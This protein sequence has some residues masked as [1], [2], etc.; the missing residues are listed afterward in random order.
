LLRQTCGAIGFA[1]LH[2]RSVAE[3]NE[4]VR[5]LKGDD[6]AETVA[7]GGLEILHTVIDSTALGPL[8]DIVIEK[9][10]ADLLSMAAAIG[11]KVLHWTD[12]FYV[13]DYLILRINFPFEVARQ[14]SPA[15]ENPGIGRVSPGVRE[16]ARSRRTVDPVYDPKSYH[17]DLPPAAWAHGPHQDSWA[18]HSEDG[19]NIWW[20]MCDTPAEAGMVLYPE[21]AGKE[22]PREP[23]T[24]YLRAGYALPKPTLLP[25]AAG[26][27]LIFDP[28]IL[29]GTHLNVSSRTRVAI[30]LR[31]NAK[32]PRFSPDCFYAREFWRRA[33]DI[34]QGRFDA[35]LHL[36]REENLGAPPLP[37][38]VEWPEPLRTIQVDYA[39]D[40]PICLG[41]SS[42][43]ADNERVL[44]QLPDRRVLV[45]RVD[46]ALVAVDARCPHYGIDLS[47]GAADR[48]R[49]FCPGCG[50]AFNLF[51]GASSAP[52]LTL[53]RIPVQEDD[54][55]ILLL[56]RPSPRTEGST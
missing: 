47:D 9:M 32:R 46:G 49:V 7:A 6:A 10:R 1:D 23:R 42:S 44:I 50:V 22:L 18:G 54:A 19:L 35:V 8:R 5:T 40:G 43:I 37:R 34:E 51:T 20:A 14:G 13:D 30:S 31:L 25:L 53:E 55:G 52:S 15:G 27:M 4:A 45:Q 26:E 38:T 21:L 36:K 48:E 11:R 29:H 56:A 17:N 12:E 41:P 16:L 33:S 28:E 39:E 2:R 3:L 24:L